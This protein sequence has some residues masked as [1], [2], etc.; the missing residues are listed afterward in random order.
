MAIKLIVGL[1]NPGKDY[2]ATRHNAGFWFVDEMA[3][4]MGAEIKKDTKFFGAMGKGSLAGLPVWLLKPTTFMNRS[5][6]AVAALA[7]FYRLLPEE[8]LVAH[9][10]L[11][12][13][14]GQIKMKKGG[15]H[16]GHNGLKD[17]QAKIGSADFWRIR[18]GIGHPRSLEMEQQVADFVLHQPSKD[19]R[20]LIDA[21]IDKA[22]GVMQ[23]CLSGQF[24]AAMLHLHTRS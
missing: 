22:A 4:R 12:L 15:G 9:D 21:D 11:D 20:R 7:N 6:Q 10:E 18:I 8:I 23:D 16:A 17:I 1:G 24:E 2:D 13:L 5:G 19:H 3:A 14:P